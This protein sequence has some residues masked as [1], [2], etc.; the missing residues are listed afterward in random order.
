MSVA[1]I[2]FVGI[3]ALI[4]WVLIELFVNLA[5]L[6]SRKHYIFWHYLV[7]LLSFGGLFS[8]YFSTFHQT[9]SVFFVMLVAM[10]FVLSF[11]IIVF[12][13]L[14]SGER[15]FLNWVDWIFPMFLAA[16]AIYAVGSFL[17]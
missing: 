1:G 11:E 17:E 6:L 2:F 9:V 4:A 15:W 10:V 3:H 8:F 14:Y 16:S 13:F 5:H 12:R 7:V